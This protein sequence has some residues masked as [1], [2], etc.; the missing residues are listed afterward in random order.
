MRKPRSR[1][2]LI[3]REILAAQVPPRFSVAPVALPSPPNFSP[4][5]NHTDKMRI[6]TCYFCSSP[7]YPSKGITFGARTHIC[8]FAQRKKFEQSC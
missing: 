2:A 3:G 6:E 1:R 5:T 8:T 7:V 4:T